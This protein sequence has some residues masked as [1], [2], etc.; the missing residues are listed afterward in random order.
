ME[1]LNDYT[2]NIVY[3]NRSLENVSQKSYPL[4]DYCQ[5]QKLNLMHV[6]TD[7]ENAFYSLQGDKSKDDWTPEA[8]ETFQRIRH[9]LLDTAN[10]IVRLPQNLYCK[11]V[12]IGAMDG[13]EYIANLVNRYTT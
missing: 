11:G 13:S 10:S 12:S 3:K 5:E 7:V 1:M 2:V 6:I 8:I 4:S 9:K